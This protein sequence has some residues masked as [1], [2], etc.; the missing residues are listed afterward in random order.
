MGIKFRAACTLE[1][2][3]HPHGIAQELCA[4]NGNWDRYFPQPTTNDS[5][6]SSSTS[7]DEQGIKDISFSLVEGDFQV[8]AGCRAKLYTIKLLLATRP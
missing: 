7:V 2:E 5:S 8:R 3:E 1:I 6:S 4:T